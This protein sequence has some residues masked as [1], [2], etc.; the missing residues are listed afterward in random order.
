MRRYKGRD[1]SEGTES[2]ERKQKARIRKR[3]RREERKSEKKG[4]NSGKMERDVLEKKK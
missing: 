2:K 1:D 4:E 3:K